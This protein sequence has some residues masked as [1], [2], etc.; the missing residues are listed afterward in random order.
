M[1]LTI[2]G[3]LKFLSMAR[4]GDSCESRFRQNFKRKFD[5][6]AFN[7][8]MLLEADGHRTAIALDHSFL[9]KSGRKTPGLG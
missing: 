6:C 1:I 3:R 4:P 5:W 9:C 8:D 7:M 2:Y